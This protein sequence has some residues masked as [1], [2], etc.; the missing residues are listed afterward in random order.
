VNVIVQV[1]L[2]TKCQ[3]LQDHSENL[4]HLDD[5]LSATEAE[6]KGLPD[7][8]FMP[9]PEVKALTDELQKHRQ[10]L[11][12]PLKQEV[13]HEQHVSKPVVL[14]ALLIVVIVG[15]LFVENYTWQEA[16]KH[17]GNDI[18]YR[19]LKVSQSPEGQKYL[20]Q[21]DS[22]YHSNPDEFRK[23]VRRQEATKQEQFEDFQQVQEKQEEIKN[24]QKK[25]NR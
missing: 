4:R 14:C 17:K 9:F 25:W 23:A 15:L 20:H 6:V 21:V 13:R 10:I 22:Q 12:I 3:R 24:L 11:A 16:D 19:Y 8:I 1:L 5:R 7:K 2:H 18:K